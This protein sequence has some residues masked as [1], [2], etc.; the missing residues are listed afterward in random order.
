M[1]LNV[2]TPPSATLDAIDRKLA[3]I[4]QH[5][6]YLRRWADDEEGDAAA[7]ATLRLVCEIETLLSQLRD[8]EPAA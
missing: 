8:Q 6:H 2:Q 7:G 3:A 1:E 4:E 5:A